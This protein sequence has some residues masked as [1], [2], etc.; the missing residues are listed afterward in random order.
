M[1]KKAEVPGLL[2]LWEVKLVLLTCVATAAATLAV[3]G[4]ADVR[5]LAREREEA[6]RVVEEERLR[7]ERAAEEAVRREE[8]RKAAEAAEAA[9]IAAGPIVADIDD[10]GTEC[11]RVDYS[12][13][14]ED[15]IVGEEGCGYSAVT[16]FVQYHAYNGSKDMGF[17]YLPALYEQVAEEDNSRHL[18]TQLSTTFSAA[19]GSMLISEYVTS[20]SIWNLEAL[21]GKIWND[22][23][24]TGRILEQGEEED[25]RGY[26]WARVVW[27]GESASAMA[28]GVFY[29][30]LRGPA[31][32][33]TVICPA[34]ADEEECL[35]REFYMDSVIGM[36]S[37]SGKGQKALTWD[38]WREKK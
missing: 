30:N 38:A 11:Y 29:V 21:C 10:T 31:R 37:F 19:D 23:G 26:T 8:E 14:S 36:C 28:K 5:S 35:Y 9:R 34:A 4:L 22:Y 20:E 12:L 27:E 1:G 13:G 32:I 18:T 7:E 15:P 6:A 2:G 25:E 33:L 3:G 17:T 16:D 24:L